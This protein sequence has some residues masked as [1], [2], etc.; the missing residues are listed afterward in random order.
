MTTLNREN[1]TKGEVLRTFGELCLSEGCFLEQP[2]GIPLAGQA[3][4][5]VCGGGPAGIAAAL[6]AARAGAKVQLI[7]LAGC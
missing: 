6:S 2:R 5:L 4:V 1:L 7:E 3:D